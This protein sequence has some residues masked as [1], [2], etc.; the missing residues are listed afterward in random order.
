MK[1]LPIINKHFSK[2]DLLHGYKATYTTSGIQSSSDYY[3]Y[4][5]NGVTDRD[6]NNNY[7][8]PYTFSQVGYVEEFAPLLGADVTMRNNMQIRAMYNKNRAYVLGVQN[9]TL[10]E[11]SGSE[12]IF[13]L[14]Y[15]IK[16]LKMRM[17]I[18]GKSRTI[19]SDLNL[20]MD[21]SLRDNKT[22]ITNIL[23]EDM[24][25]TGGQ[26]ILGVN[27]SADYN[28]SQNFQMR[29][30]YNQLVTKYKVS[31]AYPLSTI[32]AG[33]TANFTFGGNTN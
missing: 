25:V 17:T 11:D 8:N 28:F 15:I 30:F 21:I 4:Q 24:Q 3:N 27:F 18:R 7:I 5:T 9:Y 29:L 10:T 19:K 22:R 32:R 6:T 31:T 26:K 2:F 13:G 20:K 14:G 23:K 1:N 33:I 16:D 12:Y